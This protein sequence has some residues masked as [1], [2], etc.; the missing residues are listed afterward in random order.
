MQRHREL[1][2]AAEQNQQAIDVA[3]RSY[4]EGAAD[5]LSVLVAQRTL[6][7]SQSAL[8]DGATASGLALVAVYK[9]LGGGWESQ[10]VGA[11]TAASA[12]LESRLP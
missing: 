1:A 3:E 5:Y 8:A 10:A 12:P 11:S 4:R 6:L 2:I 9:S 7:A